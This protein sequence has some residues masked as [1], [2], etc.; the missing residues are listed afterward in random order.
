VLA[1]YNCCQCV[2]HTSKYLSGCNCHRSPAHTSHRHV[3]FLRPADSALNQTI[4]FTP[5]SEPAIE[6]IAGAV[7]WVFGS[8]TSTTAGNNG[9]PPLPGHLAREFAAANAANVCEFTSNDKGARRLF[10]VNLTTL[11][12]Q[13]KRLDLSRPRFWARDSPSWS[14]RRSSAWLP[15]LVSWLWDPVTFRRPGPRRDLFLLVTSVDVVRAPA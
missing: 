14:L 3:A 8:S 6:F 5:L 13:L 12:R 15:F 2:E 4:S 9:L 11:R 7:D 10:P 1:L